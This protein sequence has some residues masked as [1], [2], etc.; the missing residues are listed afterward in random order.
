MLLEEAKVARQAV[1]EVAEESRRGLVSQQ[2]AF[3]KLEIL[4]SEKRGDSYALG[5]VG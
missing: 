4:Y 2:S 1:R 5:K 3:G